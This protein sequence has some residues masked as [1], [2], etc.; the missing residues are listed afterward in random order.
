MRIKLSSIHLILLVLGFLYF[1]ININWIFSNTLPPSWDSADY[2]RASEQLYRSLTEDS[3]FEFITLYLNILKRLAPLIAV[4]PIPLYFFSEPSIQI[5]LLINIVFLLLFSLFFFLLVSRFSNNRVALF[6]LIIVLTM[7]LFYGYI[8]QFYVEFGLMSLVTIGLYMLVKTEGFS[9]RKYLIVLGII[10]GLGELMKFHYFLYM[11]GPVCITFYK[12]WVSNPSSKTTYLRL[13]PRRFMT[14][15][16]K[17]RKANIGLH[18]HIVSKKTLKRLLINLTFVAIP[19]FIIAGPW[20]INNIKNIL[21]HV[22]RATHPEILGSFYYGSPFSM[23]NIYRSLLD[24]INYSISSYYFFL[25][26]VLTSVFVFLRKKIPINYFLLSWFLIPFLIFTFGPNKANRLLL[27]AIPPIG[28]FIAYLFEN[29][30]KRKSTV[31]FS[32]AVL[33][34]IVL[35]I[36]TS[37]NF[38]NFQPNRISLGPFLLFSDDVGG[39]AVRY[40]E[41]YWP[42]EEILLFIVQL[43]PRDKTLILA[44]EHYGLNI[45]SLLYYN[46]KNNFPLKIKTASYFPQNTQWAEIN[47]L[48]ESGDILIMKIGGSAGF[49]DINRFNDTILANLDRS[50]WRSVKNDFV[51]PDGGAV[52]IFKKNHDL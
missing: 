43:E 38:V 47:S 48:I 22:K 6:S 5:A 46:F 39:N 30:F 26:L 9:N 42:I 31:L 12:Y 15:N 40:K 7:P 32:I 20:Y 52:L 11:L 28:F 50:K 24:F 4:L 44:S 17:S 1:W 33:P 37:L 8:R 34:A 35:F 18:L 2:L 13:L 45:N 41:E 21:W 29:L 49:L 36:Y 14:P 27:P 25:L 51:F 16:Q 19:A 23:D 10:Y 3:F